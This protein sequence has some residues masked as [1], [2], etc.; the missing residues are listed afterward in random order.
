ME[1]RDQLGA[2]FELRQKASCKQ[3]VYHNL[4]HK[5]ISK[6]LY[7]INSQKGSINWEN[8]V[9]EKY[10]HDDSIYGEKNV[11]CK[12]IKMDWKD[13]HQTVYNSSLYGREWGFREADE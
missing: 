13:T 11:F 6:W 1:T 9:T 5:K 7:A 10:V 4:L 12:F 2:V 3:S 8:Q